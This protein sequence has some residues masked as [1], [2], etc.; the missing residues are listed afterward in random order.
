[1]NANCNS[2]ASCNDTLAWLSCVSLIKEQPFP[3]TA[4]FNIQNTLWV[5]LLFDEKEKAK[6]KTDNFPG[7]FKKDYEENEMKAKSSKISKDRL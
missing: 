5:T 2:V 1:M 6:S 4:L 3:S 7:A